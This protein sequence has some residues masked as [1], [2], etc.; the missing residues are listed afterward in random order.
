[1]VTPLARQKWSVWQAMSE[2]LHA[3]A[4]EA[5]GERAGKPA[6]ERRSHDGDGADMPATPVDM[7]HTAMTVGTT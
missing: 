2:A 4:A 7:P 6:A 3:H 1:V 5:A